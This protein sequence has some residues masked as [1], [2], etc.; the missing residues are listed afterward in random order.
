MLNYRYGKGELTNWVVEETGFSSHL[1]G[2]T[3]TIMALGNGYLGVRSTA[4]EEYLGQKRDMFVNGTFNKFSDKEVSELPNLPDVLAINF[5]FD[6]HR[7]TLEQGTVEA[8]SKR[9]NL[10]T[11]LLT[12]EITWKTP[13]G[14]TIRFCFERFVS[15]RRK[16]VLASKVTI[17][18]DQPTAVKITSGINGQLT[19]SG[20]QHSNEEDMRFFDKTYL[21]MNTSTTQSEI[22]ISTNTTHRLNTQAQTTMFM[23][24]RK[25][26]QGFVFTLD[27]AVELEK[28]S[29]VYT[30]RDKNLE[31]MNWVQIKEYAHQQMAQVAA[32]GFAA[33][34]EESAAEWEEQ[35]WKRYPISI[36]SR[37]DYDELAI[38]FAIY[39]M[40]IMTPA[41]DSRMGI[42]AK[43][44]TGEGYKGHSFWDTEI[45]ILP[46]YMYSYPE[47]ARKLL[48]Y[49]YLGLEGARKKA[50]ENGFEGAMYP[51]EA[52]WPPDGEVTPVWGAVDIVTGEQTKI[53]SGFIEIHIT[54]DIVFMLWR[55]Y[56]STGDQDFMD[57]FGYEMIFDTASFWAS[58]LEWNESKQQYEIN[59]VVGPD[60]YKEHADNNAFTNYMSAYNL[61]LA[62]QCAKD[63]QENRPELFARLNKKLNVDA[64][65]PVWED[66][67]GK[68]YLP[69]PTAAGVVPQ[70]DGYLTY[71]TIDLEKYK[72]QEQVGSLFLDYNLEQ[73]NK[74]QVSKQ[75]D[76]MMLFYLL[77]ERFSQEVKK[78]SYAYY[79]PKTLHDSSLSLS[80]HCILANDLGEYEKAYHLFRQASEIDL[81]PNMKTSDQGIHSASLGGLW[82]CIVMGFGGMRVRNGELH[83]NPRLPDEWSELEFPICWNGATIA[84]KI[85]KEEITLKNNS[86][87]AAT[88]KV[89]G[90]EIE[91]K[92]EV[93]VKLKRAGA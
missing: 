62:I 28:I 19:N 31:E 78:A 35:V 17:S 14:K 3:E 74:L 7:F 77:E 66:K 18:A 68:I 55:Y 73:V 39:H 22:L 56:Q 69:Q 48:E 4:E 12:R 26:E 50:R 43:G 60:E 38:R 88:V 11:G 65:L 52:A 54:S 8:Y 24:R 42:G 91:L 64:A 47:V 89:A 57:R 30:S 16:N 75:A 70:D 92:N 40:V 13:G 51:W 2:K 76:I 45:F 83:F 93:T 32:L 36:K 21:Q 85:T 61:E 15:L 33:L 63:L 37:H 72:N 58:R 6:G 79:E 25:M 20:S 59:N 44:L 71:P 27:G 41:H 34:A 86:Q 23:D 82:Q 46:F 87:T 84:V 9:L 10:K 81:G 1:Q 29:A 80:T 53:W 5:E 67:V 90:Q 49:R